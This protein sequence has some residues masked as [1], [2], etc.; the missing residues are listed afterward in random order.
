MSLSLFFPAFVL[1]DSQFGIETKDKNGGKNRRI[2]PHNRYINSGSMP[3]RFEMNML[4]NG[5]PKY[6]FTSRGRINVRSNCAKGSQVGSPAS[7]RSN[8]SRS[9]KTGTDPLKSTL[10]GV[11]SFRP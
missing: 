8:E 4:S 3:S 2:D 7:R 5:N 6:L 11:P 10:Y 9:T 1:G